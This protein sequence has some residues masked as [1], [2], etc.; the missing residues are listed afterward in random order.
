ME[1]AIFWAFLGT[2][3]TFFMTVLGAGMVHP[4]VLRMCGYDPEKWQGFAFGMAGERIAMLKYNMND[5]RSMHEN[6]LRETNV[7][8]RK[9]V[10]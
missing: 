1:Q 9:E 10:K 8:D 4:N 5:M 6:D 3:F 2:G 7:F